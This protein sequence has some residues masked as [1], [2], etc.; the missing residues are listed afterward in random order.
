MRVGGTN[1]DVDVARCFEDLGVNVEIL[2]LNDILRR[3]NLGTYNGLV[4]PGGF[5]YGDY[6]RAG[7]I[8]AKR[9]QAFL[10]QDLKLFAEAGKPII[11]ICNGFQVL[12]EAGLLPGGGAEVQE[13]SDDILKAALASNKSGKFECR[14]VYMKKN[15]SS[16][17]IFTSGSPEVVRFPVA[18]GEGRF[19]LGN[20]GELLKQLTNNNQIVLQYSLPSGAIANGKYPDNPNGSLKDIAGICNP[21]GTIFGLMPHPEDAYWNYQLPDWTSS[22]ENVSKYGDGRSIFQSM[23]EHIEKNA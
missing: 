21:S 6:V 17:C 8:W 13:S 23:I 2:H 11:G 9:I 15:S 1:R 12:V 3:R 7:A 14:W 20:E 4:F 5:A 19:I 22:K 10:K 16:K 18:H